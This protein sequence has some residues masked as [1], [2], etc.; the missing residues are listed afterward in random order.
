MNPHEYKL[1]GSLRRLRHLRP[2]WPVIAF[3]QGEGWHMGIAPGGLRV[4][5]KPGYPLIYLGLRAGRGGQSHD[6]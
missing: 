2:L 5:H 6:R 1:R 4:L 3:A